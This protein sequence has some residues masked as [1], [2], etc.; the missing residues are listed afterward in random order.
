MSRRHLRLG[1]EDGRLFAEDLNSLN[2]TLLDG[3]ALPP[4]Q[5]TPLVEDQLLVLGDVTLTLTRLDD[6]GER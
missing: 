5:P 2:G 6:S 3:E 4:F 1:V